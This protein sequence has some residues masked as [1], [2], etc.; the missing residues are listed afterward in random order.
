MR[1]TTILLIIVVL[2]ACDTDSAEPKEIVLDLPSEPYEYFGDA[3]V[4]TL[5]R[6]LF[7]DTKLSINNAISC[8]SCHKQEIAFSD[9]KQFSRGFE[10][11]STT[12]NS[13]PIQNLARPLLKNRNETNLLKCLAYA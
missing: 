4:A 12:R 3:N 10:N 13:M 8:A 6:V 9:N 5:G 11:R 1:L 2:S 7:Y